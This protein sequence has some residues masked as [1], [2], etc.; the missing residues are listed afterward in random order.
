MGIKT[1]H[2]KKKDSFVF[3][4]NRNVLGVKNFKR[5]ALKQKS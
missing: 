2:E 5:T 1:E 3:I 4:K